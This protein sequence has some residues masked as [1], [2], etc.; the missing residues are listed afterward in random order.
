MSELLDLLQGGQVA[1]EF[2]KGVCLDAAA[3][4]AT[5]IGAMADEA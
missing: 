4:L 3:A 2:A 1:D 5:S